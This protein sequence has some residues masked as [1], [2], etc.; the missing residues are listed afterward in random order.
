MKS[1]FDKKTKDRPLQ[2]GD[3]VLR[4]DVRREDKGKHEKFDQLWLGPFKIY[5]VKGNNTYL[6]EN[7]EGES[8]ELPV[9]DQFLKPY[10]QN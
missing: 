8:Q 4:W 6:L 1:L 9:N 3:L 5:E 2:P 7:M 10:F